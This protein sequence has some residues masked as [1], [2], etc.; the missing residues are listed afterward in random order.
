MI[1]V[2]KLSKAF[3]GSSVLTDLDLCVQKGSIYGLIGKNGAGKTTLI[4]LLTG[5]YKPDNGEITFDG[6]PVYDDEEL[7][8]KIAVVYDS[9]YFPAGATLASMEK[10]YSKIYTCWDQALFEKLANVFQLDKK[11]SLRRFSKGMKKQAYLALTL[12]TKPDYMFLD[13]PMD[14]LD[15][16]VRKVIS[17]QIIDQVCEREMTVIISSHNLRELEGMCDTIGILSGGKM[18]LEKELDE[19]KSA[20]HK[21]Q[22]SF[23]EGTSSWKLPNSLN[24]LHRTVHGSV[25][26]LIIRETA[27]KIRS[28]IEPEN[29]RVFDIL[30][31]TLE[32]L[33]IY[34]LGGENDEIKE[35]L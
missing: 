2:K 11:K 13:E 4:H 35:I 17:G 18:K 22:V 31:I 29:P 20:M 1:E 12:A 21:V 33:F 15:P 27:E 32:E 28:V 34:E 30:P 3:N 6:K 25:E 10:E 26:L 24:I 19:I 8:E 14:G 7:K 5:I 16:I 9:P 23:A